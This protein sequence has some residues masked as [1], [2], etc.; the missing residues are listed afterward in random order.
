M[1]DSNDSGTQAGSTIVSNTANVA[2]YASLDQKGSV[3]AEYVWIDGING[4]RSKTKVS[5]LMF[6]ILHLLSLPSF[7]RRIA[8]VNLPG[9]GLLRNQHRRSLLTRERSHC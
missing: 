7:Y 3:M 9:D 8:L 6:T 5:V 2:K 1:A 4:L